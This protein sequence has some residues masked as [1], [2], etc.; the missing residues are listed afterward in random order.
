M[1][2]TAERTG[3]T[4]TLGGAASTVALWGLSVPDWAVIVSAAVAVA[5]FFLHFFAT[6]RKEKRAQEL[7]AAQLEGLRNGVTKNVS[8]GVEEDS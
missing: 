7:H 4:T 8:G 6:M 5:G 3:A 1:F 2:E